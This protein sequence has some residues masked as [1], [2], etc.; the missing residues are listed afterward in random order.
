MRLPNDER[1]PFEESPHESILIWEYEVSNE[2]EWTLE[3]NLERDGGH[4]ANCQAS[5]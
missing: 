3:A 4:G 1:A 5:V 2:R